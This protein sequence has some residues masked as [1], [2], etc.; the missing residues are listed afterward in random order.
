MVESNNNA[1]T[2]QRT[3]STTDDNSSPLKLDY[4]IEDPR[5]RTKIVQQIINSTPKEKLSNKCLEIL[6]DYI[7]FAMDKEQK[8][9]KKV[10]TENRMVTINKRETSFEG[11]VGKLENGEDGIYNMVSDNKNQLLT[12]KISITQKDLDEIPELRQIKII[13]DQLEK[14]EKA[15][16]GKRKF[17]LK[18]QI[19]EF[20]QDQYIIKNSVRK[21][22]YCFHPSK[23]LPLTADLCGNVYVT[24]EGE[25]VDTSLIS[26]CDYKHVSEILCNYSKIKQDVYG[27]FSCDMYFLMEELDEIVTEALEEKYPFYYQLLIYKIDGLMNSDIQKKLEEEFG[28]TYTIE[29]L[30]SLWRNKIPKLIAD[31]AQEKYLLWYYTFVEKGHWKRCSRC[32]QIKLAHNRFFS[33]NKTSKDGFYSICKECRNKKTTKEGTK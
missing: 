13:I 7:I 32:G 11:L 12:P 3:S 22:M 6:S 28:T 19:I 27:N 15:A 21:P 2:A 33:K 25:V 14:A 9:Q 29:Y 4:T 30:S 1:A 23:S 16:T 5:E 18:K 10:L 31:K 24:K 17:L 20:R 8:K 26:L